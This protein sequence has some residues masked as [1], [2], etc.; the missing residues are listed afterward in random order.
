MTR[1]ANAL[2]RERWNGETGQY[3]VAHRERHLAEHKRLHPHLFDAAGIA[4][5]DRVLDVGCGCGATTIAAAKAA[6][7]HGTAVGVDPSSPML[8]VARQLAINAAAP[9]AAFVRGDAQFCP[10]RPESCDVISS[11]GVMFFEDPAAALSSIAATVR[12]H[13]RLAFLCWQ[14][15]TRNELFSIPLAAFGGC[16]QGPPQAPPSLFTDP[17][18]ITAL[19]S[20]TGWDSIQVRPLAEPAWIG[21]D[22][23]D[24]LNYVRG[25]SM[26]R[27]LIA[28]QADPEQT[29]QA[30]HNLGRQYAARQQPDGI[31][32]NA[33]A[34]LVTARRR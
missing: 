20:G 33:A 10:L 3:W 22:V 14:D 25:M 21:T 26:I 28:D 15:D 17:G 9:N 34:W 1:T 7:S 23:T 32:V 12:R 29:E 18:K 2:Q 5:G 4:P 31:W 6:A 27:N 13:G 11:F 24:V 19:L 30:M 16:S 8:A